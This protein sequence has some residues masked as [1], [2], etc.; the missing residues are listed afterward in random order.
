M[1][2]PSPFALVTYVNDVAYRLVADHAVRF[3]TMPPRA[4]DYARA[5]IGQAYVVGLPH[6]SAAL[7]VA[8]ELA[9]GL[10]RRWPLPGCPL[11]A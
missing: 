9:R 6:E 8:D 3:A 10:W 1:T 4:R 2:H 7:A 11:A 5:R